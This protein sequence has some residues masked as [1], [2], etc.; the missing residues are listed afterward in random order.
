MRAVSVVTFLFKLAIDW[1]KSS[2]PFTIKTSGDVGNAMLKSYLYFC[3]FYINQKSFDIGY[4]LDQRETFT[5]TG[6]NSQ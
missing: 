1:I 5:L 6:I 3:C 4:I 2:P